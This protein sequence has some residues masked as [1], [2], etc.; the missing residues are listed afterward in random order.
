MTPRKLMDLPPIALW[1]PSDF[2]FDPIRF[3]AYR[4]NQLQ[5]FLAILS[6]VAKYILLQ[7]PTGCGK[8]LIAA[9]LQRIFEQ[10]LVYTCTTTLLQDQVLRDFSDCLVDREPFGV[11]LKGRSNYRTRLKPFPAWNASI[12][13]QSSEDRRHCAW[14]CENPDSTKKSNCGGEGR[15]PYRLAKQAAL[16]SPFPILNTSYFLN[17]SEYAG[18]FTKIPWLVLD[19]GDTGE[20][21]LM[22]F[23]S[24][25]FTEEWV[26]RLEVGLPE[27]KTVEEAWVRWVKEEAYPKALMQLR[28]IDVQLGF[29][30]DAW[31]LRETELA[32]DQQWLQRAVRKMD[33]FLQSVASRNWVWLPDTLSFKPIRVGQYG[34]RYI[35]D[36]AERVVIMSATLLSP[37]QVCADLGIPRDGVAWID[38]DSDFPARRRPVYYTPVVALTHKTEEEALP[39]ILAEVDRIIEE[40]KGEKGVIHTVSYSRAAYL[41]RNSRHQARLFSYGAAASRNKALDHF[42]KSEDDLVLVASSMDRGVDLPNELCR[43]QIICKVPWPNKGDRQVAARLYSGL[44]GQRWYAVKTVRSIIQMAGR[45]MRHEDDWCRTYILDAQFGPLW[46]QWR[47]LFPKWFQEAVVMKGV[48]HAEAVV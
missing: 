14:C 2:G 11:T 31:G 21:A 6:T 44:Q 37:D 12:C 34:Q 15:C 36:K 26:K 3:P 8:S 10:Q 28:A 7:G 41:M 40:H 47:P 18:I 23:M 48:D 32:K 20:D 39:Q 1:K 29:K 33:F 17:A 35:F 46:A 5:A 25:T 24:L 4:P 27:K 19:E 42:K 9:T 38:L 13:Q 22:D 30:G 16:D 45:G 43:F